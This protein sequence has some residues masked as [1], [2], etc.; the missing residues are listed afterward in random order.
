[1]IAI[2]ICGT[3]KIKKVVEIFGS[4]VFYLYLCIRKE[5]DFNMKKIFNFI[6]GIH[7]FSIINKYNIGDICFWPAP[8]DCMVEP[9]I[10]I[11]QWSKYYDKNHN[12]EIVLYDGVDIHNSTEYA[13]INEDELQILAYADEIFESTNQLTEKETN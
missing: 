11:T 5:K 8:V 4:L 3:K 7:N 1:M 13:E 2:T 9:T 6:F 10:R 12:K